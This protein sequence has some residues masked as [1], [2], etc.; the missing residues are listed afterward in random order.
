MGSRITHYVPVVGEFE[1]I[2]DPSVGENEAWY[3]NDH[4]HLRS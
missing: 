4:T 1:R 3:I 2:Y